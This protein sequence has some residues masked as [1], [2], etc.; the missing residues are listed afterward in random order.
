V[1]SSRRGSSS[2]TDRL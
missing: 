2:G 1:P